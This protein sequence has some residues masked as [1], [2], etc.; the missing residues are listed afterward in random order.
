MR[1]FGMREVS[2]LSAIFLFWTFVSCEKPEENAVGLSVQPG[3]DQLG[4]TIDSTTIITRSVLQD[5]LRS[6]ELSAALLGNLNDL[7]FGETNAGIFTQLR[8]PSNNI[9]FANA[10]EIIVDSVILA[11]EYSG[12]YGD[13]DPQDFN[14]SLVTESYY[15]DSNYYTNR[16]V[17]T[18]GIN[19][20]LPGY[21]NITPNLEDSVPVGTSNLPAQIR[22][23]LDSILAQTIV[24]NSGG[25]LLLNN[26]NFL[27]TVKGIY[28]TSTSVL[29]VNKGG[30]LYFN[31]NS[32]NSKYTIYY[33]D[34][35]TNAAKDFD[36]IIDAGAAR[37]TTTSHTYSLE[38]QNQLL[39]S[40]LGQQLFYLQTTAGLN[41]LVYF[42]NI[43][44]YNSADIA[45]SKAE[46]ILPVSNESVGYDPQES[47]F[48][49]GLKAD[50][51]LDFL[52]DQFEGSAHIDGNYNEIDNEYRFTITRF[53]QNQII[54]N[55]YVALQV[56]SSAASVTG[57]RVIINGG[58]H[59]SKR[60]KLVLT[61]IN[62]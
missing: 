3:E 34:T 19:M 1:L 25:D 58:N 37:F 5:S 22:F 23:R 6:D 56:T 54:S 49:Y 30:L 27:Q 40:T 9:S 50:G 7:K 32:I 21:E 48:L 33:H 31:L 52:L 59:V 15:L 13:L 53:I 42:P 18:T 8:L 36:L 11:L 10:N 24:N 45:V 2:I 57:N 38:I 46:L 41:A 47:L 62:L 44:N 16:V 20:I 12:D 4:L 61:Y 55:D 17:N 14:I 29:G 35:L 28:I 60:A 26:D 43:Q 39:D 51:T